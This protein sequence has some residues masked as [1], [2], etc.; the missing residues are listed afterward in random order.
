MATDPG[1]AECFD[2]LGFVAIG[3]GAR[4]AE[5]TF[6]A[7]AYAPTFA[8]V[9]AAFVAFE[10]RRRAESAP[11]VG[12]RLTDLVHISSEIKQFDS[13]ARD[14]F[15]AMYRELRDNEDKMRKTIRDVVQSPSDSPSTENPEEESE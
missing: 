13:K 15:D 6:I 2:A 3:S 14:Q 5:A 11:G 8:A 1:T 9:E 12:R 4:H 7:H 10:G